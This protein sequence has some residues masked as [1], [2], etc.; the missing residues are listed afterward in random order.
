MCLLTARVLFNYQD[1]VVTLLALLP[2]LFLSAHY[3]QTNNGNIPVASFDWETKR[4]GVTSLV[5]FYGKQLRNTVGIT[6]ISKHY[7]LI[8]WAKNNA[9]SQ[10]TYSTTV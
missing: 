7:K 4:C 3:S 1:V 9:H 8:I 5:Y 10:R 2:L 6:I